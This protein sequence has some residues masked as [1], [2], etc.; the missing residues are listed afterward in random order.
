M[1]PQ[2]VTE[3]VTV[4]YLREKK[5][6]GIAVMT[7]YDFALARL[8]DMAEMDILLVGDSLGMVFQGGENTLSVTTEQMIYHTRWVAR[9]AR[10]ALVVTD[11]PFLSYQVGCAQAIEN[12]GQF[13]QAGAAA[14]KLEGGEA[15]V[16][17]IAQLTRYDIPVMA[18]IGL[19]PQS[20]HRMGGY[21][22]QGR[23]PMEA[24]RLLND[25]RAVEQAGAFAVVLE[26]IPMKLAAKITKALKIPTIGIGSG[27]HCDGQVL[28]L[29][30]LL[31][32]SPKPMPRF[33]RCYAD[34]AAVALDAFT[35]FKKD[36]VTGVFPSKEEGYV[37][38]APQV[39]RR[40]SR[41]A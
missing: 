34:V 39:R 31:G 18:H 3:R 17:R 2:T 30:D 23:T 37:S 29:N 22:V 35:R 13:L 1:T 24:K 21:R 14:V 20:V 10:R 15:V 40:A 27:P 6:G 11:M 4:P 26:A 8:A 12:A 7:A 28:V 33:V 36:V 9:A 19:T 5:G 41:P 25:A 38:R 32:L 16:D